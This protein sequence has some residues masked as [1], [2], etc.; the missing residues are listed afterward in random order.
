MLRR[1]PALPLLPL[2]ILLHGCGG[3]LATA[4]VRHARITSTSI[5]FVGTGV[6][7]EIGSFGADLGPA[8][9]SL[10]SGF[11][12]VL[13]VTRIQIAWDDPSP[14]P[15]P[16][17]SGVTSATLTAIP[18]PT[19]GLSEVVVATYLQDPAN[20]SPLA[21]VIEG[22]TNVNLFDY[23]ASGVLTLRLDAQ[24][25]PAPFA[26]TATVIA[27]LTLKVEFSM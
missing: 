10:G 1:L 23:L 7:G 24:G 12:T 11:T 2:A 26:D 5:P 18:D 8:G 27:D 9:T 17:F 4:E 22:D 25:T 16:D 21:L 19:S 14:L 13:K 3:P 6:P 15:Y 20:P